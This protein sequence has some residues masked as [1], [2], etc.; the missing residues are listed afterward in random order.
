M[1]PRVLKTVVFLGSGR[2][3]VAP[4][5]GPSRLGDRVLAHVLDVLKTRE[6]K[7]GDET[8]RHD[9]T[10]YDPLEVFGKGGA[11]EESGA[12]IRT[13]H[14]YFKEGEAPPAMEKM[15]E[16]IKE[17]DAYLIVTPE[18]NHAVSP[19]VSSLL[20]HFGGSNY[21]GKTSGIVTYSVGPWGGARGGTALKP[22]LSELGCVSVSKMVHFPV[23]H[24]VS[25]SCFASRVTSRVTT[26][27]GAEDSPYPPF[28]IDKRTAQMFSESGEPVDPSN[29]MLKQLPALLGQLEWTAIALSNMRAISPL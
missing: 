7:I 13:P 19:A 14:F 25:C 6:N 9:V 21:I 3:I 26:L 18:Y 29:R 4:W 17:A 16:T 23:A 20:G 8:V 1:A 5:G 10:V 11:L 15:R 12:I 28:H 2:D 27:V 24:E 22:L